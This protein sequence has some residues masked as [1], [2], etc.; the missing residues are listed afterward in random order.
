MNENWD[1][2]GTEHIVMR[3]TTMQWDLIYV[4]RREHIKM[5]PDTKEQK[6][7]EIE[8]KSWQ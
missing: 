8:P 2:N 7:T 1:G 6:K 5:V 3:P 4:I